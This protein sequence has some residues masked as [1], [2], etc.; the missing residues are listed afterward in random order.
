MKITFG[1]WSVC[2]IITY[3][4]PRSGRSQFEAGKR[5]LHHEVSLLPYQSKTFLYF[6]QATFH[7][8]EPVRWGDQNLHVEVSSTDR[9]WTLIL[10][11]LITSEVQTPLA[12]C[13]IYM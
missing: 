12:L 13:R 2:V 9:S 10:P 11:C 4:L 5:L 6:F 7:G 3:L 1:D 8:Q